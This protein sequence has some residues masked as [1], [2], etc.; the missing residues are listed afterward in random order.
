VIVAFAVVVLSR[1]Y[2]DVPPWWASAATDERQRATDIA[3][4]VKRFLFMDASYYVD[5]LWSELIS[6]F[7]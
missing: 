2:R 6:G 5:G 3:K 4:M 1:S 7:V